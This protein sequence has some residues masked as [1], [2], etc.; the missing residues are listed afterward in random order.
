MWFPHTHTYTYFSIVRYRV[1]S[2]VG[3]ASNCNRRLK[4]PLESH[5][6]VSAKDT[7]L[8]GFIVVVVVVAV[9]IVVAA[10]VENY[11]SGF[12]MQLLLPVR[13]R[14]TG[15]TRC[16]YS[17]RYSCCCYCQELS[18]TTYTEHD[19]RPMLSLLYTS[20]FPFATLRALRK[21]S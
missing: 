9:V 2:G 5:N 10:T 15:I 3:N 17:L 8:Q 12:V 13:S 14:A 7:R 16:R 20:S 18:T 19:I 11:R 21:P 6:A 1:F 4:P